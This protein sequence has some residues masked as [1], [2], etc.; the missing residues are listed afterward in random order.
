MQKTEIIGRIGND[1]EVNEAGTGNTV[2]NFNVAVSEKWKDK[3]GNK[4]EKTTWYRCAWWINN[5]V[6]S[7]YLKKGTQVY[8]MGTAN[9]SAY[10]NKTTGDIVVQEGINVRSLELLGGGNTNTTSEPAAN[11]KPVENLT[12]EE[13]DDLPF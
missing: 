12:E 4:Q 13:E 1:A 11:Y 7:T 8:V 9:A 5:T 10:T 2:I 6:I 3:Q